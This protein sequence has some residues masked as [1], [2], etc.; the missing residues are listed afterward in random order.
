M[1]VYAVL[2]GKSVA[3]TVLY[4]LNDDGTSVELT[5]LIEFIYHPIKKAAKKSAFSELNY[6][7]GARRFVK[8]HKNL[9][10]AKKSSALLF[11]D[12]IL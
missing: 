2:R 1:G 5:R 3:K 4:Q 10:F 7:F 11:Y 6:F 12:Y 8:D 9:R